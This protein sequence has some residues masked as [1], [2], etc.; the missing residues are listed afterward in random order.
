MI[1]VGDTSHLIFSY[2]SSDL[3]RRPWKA[4]VFGHL[5]FSPQLEPSTVIK[6]RGMVAAWD[7]P[8]PDPVYQG[9]SFKTQSWS[10]NPGPKRLYR[11]SY[12]QVLS[13]HTLSSL[14]ADVPDNMPLVL[15]HN[16]LSPL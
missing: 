9:V 6:K 16:L 15:F 4:I 13:F 3:L 10:I 11:K 1:K 7:H 12:F 14:E 2:E 5:G 8:R